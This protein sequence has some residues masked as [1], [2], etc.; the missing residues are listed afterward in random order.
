MSLR[1][2]PQYQEKMNTTGINYNEIYNNDYY[3]G[4]RQ[5]MQSYHH[6]SRLGVLDFRKG[7]KNSDIAQLKSVDRKNLST[8]DCGDTQSKFGI[9]F[10]VE[11]NRIARGAMSNSALFAGF[12]RDGSCG[13]EG[14][15]NILPL[16]PSGTWRNKVFS[17]MHD[18]RRVIE[19]SYS[20]SDH[21]C[22]GHVTISVEGMSGRD[23]FLAVR[24]NVGILYALFRKRLGNRYCNANLPLDVDFNYTRYCTIQ[25]KQNVVE[26]RLVN[27]FQSVKQMMRRYELFYEI[28]DFSVNN[29]NGSHASLL[30]KIRPIVKSMYNGNDEKT[31]EILALAKA[32]NKYFKTGKVNR[33]IINH[34][35]PMRRLDPATHYDRDL[36]RNG[37]R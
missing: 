12:E 11:K 23:L 30:K 32:F 8:M 28:V 37:W 25:Q 2:L 34:V 9:G 1:T 17:M 27:R 4:Q 22:G 10:E 14:V 3:V 7:A 31:D 16:L 36:Q 6:T 5:T 19:D 21:R 18:A 15:T 35:D 26:F 29:P 33:E 24:E 13:Y 20:P